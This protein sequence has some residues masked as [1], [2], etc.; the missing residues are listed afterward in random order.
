MQRITWF[1]L[2]RYAAGVGLEPWFL[3]GRQQDAG[4]LRGLMVVTVLVLIMRNGNRAYTFPNEILGKMAHHYFS[5]AHPSTSDYMLR[6]AQSAKLSIFAR[7][8]NKLINTN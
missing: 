7:F 6:S 3:A 8:W 1:S 5:T 2:H 4:K